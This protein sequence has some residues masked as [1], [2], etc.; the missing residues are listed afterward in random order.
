MMS[1]T[2]E[3]PI[4]LTNLL[5]HYW[6]VWAVGSAVVV[7]DLNKRINQ[8]GKICPASNKRVFADQRKLLRV[9]SDIVSFV[10]MDKDKADIKI[11]QIFFPSQ[12]QGFVLTT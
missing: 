7:E 8:R 12:H 11:L 10:K 5:L 3:T 6:A 4:T 1:L 2:L 9:F